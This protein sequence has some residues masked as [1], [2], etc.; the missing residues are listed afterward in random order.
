MQSRP[1]FQLRVFNDYFSNTLAISSTLSAELKLKYFII[2][3]KKN[4]ALFN[5]FCLLI[6]IR[7]I[8]RYLPANHPT[9]CFKGMLSNELAK[10]QNTTLDTPL[11]INYSRTVSL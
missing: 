10:G 2:S 7:F 3:N 6:S 8:M 4:M 11:I 1:Q 5:E 9:V